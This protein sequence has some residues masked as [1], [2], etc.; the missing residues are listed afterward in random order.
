[1]SEGDGYCSAPVA[2][3]KPTRMPEPHDEP[4]DLKV[5][6]TLCPSCGRAPVENASGTC[7]GCRLG[8][9]RVRRIERADEAFRDRQNKVEKESK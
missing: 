6:R 9:R 4:N 3:L 5:R 2:D 1:M 8:T 7:N